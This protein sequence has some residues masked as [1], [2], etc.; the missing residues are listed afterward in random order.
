MGDME[1][2]GIAS[3]AV[4]RPS[5][6]AMGISLNFPLRG[7]KLVGVI[8]PTGTTAA[9]P[10]R[11][12][13]ALPCTP[14]RPLGYPPGATRRAHAGGPGFPDPARSPTPRVRHPPD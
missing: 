2:P 10:P 5:E 13:A 11:G 9:P 4:G 7:R 6:R 14:L 3:Y 12:A 8:L 1:F